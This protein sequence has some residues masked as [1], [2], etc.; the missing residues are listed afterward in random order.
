MNLAERLKAKDEAVAA[1]EAA[2]KHLSDCHSQ[3]AD[4]EAKDSQAKDAEAAAHLAIHDL[5]KT[6]GVHY[7]ID[8]DGTL[9]TYHAVDVPPGW[10]A[11]HPIPGD[12]PDSIHQE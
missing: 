4:A 10:I 3:L 11:Q 7:M 8:K 9:T 12:L 5:I 6:D 1:S 2:D